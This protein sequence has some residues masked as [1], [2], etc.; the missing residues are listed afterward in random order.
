VSP[1]DLERGVRAATGPGRHV[2]V[3][4]EPGAVSD[5]ALAEAAAVLERHP[6]VGIVFVTDEEFRTA[7]QQGHRWL[8]SAAAQGPDLVAG[9]YAVL[10]RSTFIDAGQQLPRTR[11][12][13]LSLWLRAAALADVAHVA[14]VADVADVTEPRMALSPA[15]GEPSR[16]QARH[17]GEITELHERAHAFLDLFGG[18]APVRSEDRLRAAACRALARSARRR[19]WVAAYEGDRVEASLCRHLAHDVTCWRRERCAHGR[20]A[21][22]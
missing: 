18:F 1:V 6:G 13:E 15:F 19:A 21:T 8:R 14:D 4:H 16:R 22:A 7:P 17:V 11:H 20:L 12:E 5:R 10:R 9:R 3:A 2:V